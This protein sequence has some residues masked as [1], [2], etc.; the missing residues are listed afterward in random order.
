MTLASKKP[1][2]EDTQA[3]R[4][5]VPGMEKPN[6][7]LRKHLLAAIG[8]VAL[9]V[10]PSVAQDYNLA[11][12]FGQVTLNAGFSPDP[13][14]VEIVA[15]G[16]IDANTALGTDFHNNSCLGM[17]AN[18]P[19][20]RVNYTAGSWPLIFNVM[21]EGDTTLV[22]NAPDGEWYCDDDGAGYPN[23][24]IEFAVPLS[25]QYDIWIGAYSGGNPDATLNVTELGGTG[26]QTPPPTTGGLMPDYNL[27]PT[28]GQMNLTA[29]FTPDPHSVD[30]VAGGP[31]EAGD[32]LGTDANGNYCVGTIAEAP[33]YRI[34]YTSGSW[35]LI[36]NVMASEDTT[37]VINA[38]DGQWYCNDD[39]AGYP[40]PEIVFDTPMSGQYDIWVGAYSGGN[41]DATLN[42]TE[43]GG[44]AGPVTPPS[45]PPANGGM[46]D[47]GLPPT[48]G[49]MNLTAG[50]TP[51]PHTV[52]IVAGGPIDAGDALGTDAN[53]NYCI[54]TIAE[55]PDYRINYT[56]G[57]WPLIFN[58]MAS[59]D[60]TLV[61][62]APDGQWY[63]N[64]DG[65]GY[66]N[67][68]IV[69]DTPMSGQYDIWIGAYSG[70]N[71]DATLN[72]TELAGDAGPVTPPPSMPPPTG[73]MP[74]FTLSPTY[75]Q[76]TLTAGFTPDPHTINLTAGGEI[77]ALDALGGSCRGD[78]ATAPDYSLNYT[79][80]SWPLYIWA[81]ADADTTIVINGPDGQWYCDDDSAGS[82]NPLFEFANP[83]SGRYD[84]WVGTYSG[85]T[86]P[87]T[88]YISE[89]GP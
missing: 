47:F 73:N 66:P 80:G 51:D 36:F 20:Y 79:S 62:N 39:G 61:I 71:P 54:G 67:P 70:G 50:F 58:V 63:C 32:A 40:N 52:A 37:L 38:P 45:M 64:D 74:D 76:V 21:S 12:T 23:P 60:T 48:F 46:P 2:F 75:G 77:D 30:L 7:M 81:I 15:G 14:S 17:I 44:N 87:A 42:V 83:Q 33:D 49:Q 34:N 10:S 6:K 5:I 88:L 41:P 3:V 19:D 69:F 9:G 4:L 89:L 22:I 59:E 1:G 82:L 29:G 8:L 43:L 85:G 25:G 16:G 13:H 24:M 86:A 57:S 31:V 55:A 35:P 18:A 28:F 53:G 84:I 78:I 56:S 11:P 65:A 27:P 72:V 68:E 26:G